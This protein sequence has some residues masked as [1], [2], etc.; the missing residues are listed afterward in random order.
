MDEFIV[1]YAEKMHGV[2]SGFDRVVFRGT[3][4]AIRYAEGMKAYLIRKGLWV[5]DFAQ[6]VQVVNERLKQ[7]SLAEAQKLGRKV[8]YLASSQID[9]DVVARRI[10][11]EQK[12]TSGPVCVLTCVEPCRS[13]EVYRN[14]ETK[15]L[16]LVSRL[17]KCLFLYHYGIHPVFGFMNARLQTWFPFPVQICLNGREWLARQMEAEGLRY[18]RQEN[19]FPWIEDFPRAQQL[20]DQQVKVNW[21]RHLDAIADQLHPLRTELFDDFPA[22]YYWSTYQ[23]EWSTDLVF[24][25]PTVLKRLY[26]FLMYHALTT[27]GSP[28]VMRFLGRKVPVHGGVDGN[29][30]GEVRSDLRER[31]EGIRIKH[32]VDGNSVKAYGKALRVEGSVFR[33]ETTIQC[34]KNFK[35]YRRKEGDR[36]G[37]KA[38]RPMR[39]GIADLPRRARVS[40]QCNERYLGALASVEATARLDELTER[41][42]RRTEWK[43]RQMRGLHPFGGPDSTLFEAISRGEWTV[44]GFRNGDLQGLLW[45][46][47]AGSGEEKRRRSARV[48]RQIRLLRAHGLIQKV[49]HENRYHLTAFGRMAVTTVLAARQASVS[50]LNEKAA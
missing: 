45:S 7:S 27:F 41:L 11:T 14:R 46:H 40:Q 12:I 30:E 42:E 36:K 8:L 9:K 21:R 28:D 1:K 47:P 44:R 18:A 34:P 49:P 35:V 50:D 3:L 6:H 38:W 26:P 39:R 48:S 24:R 20:L 37:P 16:D 22:S 13:F 32:S 2:I 10:A 5:G 19:C 43:G 29:F 31:E 17:R 15:K 33:V 4:R 23:T 25:D